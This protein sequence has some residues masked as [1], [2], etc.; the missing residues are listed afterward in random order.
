MAFGDIIVEIFGEIFVT[1]IWRKIILPFFQ[2]SGYGLRLLF[3]FKGTTKD[4]IYSSKD[5][6]AFIGVFFWVATILTI[7]ILVN[8][9]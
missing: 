4:K 1:I 9:K 3:N 5:F 6:N 2:L 7:I 8:L